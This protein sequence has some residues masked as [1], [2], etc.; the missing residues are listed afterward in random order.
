ME[1]KPGVKLGR[2]EILSRIG[3]GGMGQVW[4]AR[5]TRLGR[6]VAVK[7]SN[8]VFSGRFEREAQAIS[9]LNHPNICTLYDVGPDY[10]VMELVEGETLSARLAR[11]PL[12]V[13]L[14][15]QY[16]AQIAAALTEA[17]S[18]RI[19]HR[20]LKPANIML[21]RTGVKILDFGVAKM[22]TAEATNTISGA[23]L[24]TP[25][26]MA[27]EQIEGKPSDSRTDI[28]ALG[29]VLYEM[30]TGRRLSYRQPP[31]AEDLPAALAPIILRC[32]ETDPAQ[33][34]DS[35]RDVLEQLKLSNP[36]VPALA[37]HPVPR[38]TIVWLAGA[39]TLGAGA[40]WLTKSIRNGSTPPAVSVVIPIPVGAATADPGRLL[41]PPV[42][43]P[44]GNAVVVS[45]KTTQGDALFIR[46]LDSD[47]LVRLD[48][49]EGASYPF[50]SPDSKHMGFF[51]GS[52]MKRLPA[53]G[54]APATICDAPAARGGAWGSRGTIIFGNGLGA[55]FN[56]SES[57]GK[58]A[59]ATQL[60]KATGENSHRYPVFLPDGNR[61]LY[62]A[63]TDN[64]EKRGIYMEALNRQ[65]SR[66]RIIQADGQFALGRDPRSGRYSILTQQA[67]KIVAQ[68]FDTGRGDL[69]GEPY[70]LLNRAGQVSVSDS[71]VLL[72]RPEK[73]D[74]SRLVWRDRAGREIG[75]LGS[76]NDYWGVALSPD[77][78]FAAAVK[79]DYLS[80]QFT[81]WMAQLPQGL[82]EPFSS[83]THAYA[84]AWSHDSMA[85][86]YCDFRQGKLFRRT[87]T[88]AG[89]E[90]SVR[91]IRDVGNGSVLVRDISPDGR[92]GV[93]EISSVADRSEVAWIAMNSEQL[94]PTGA[95][96][97]PGLLPRLSPDGTWLAQASSQ[98]GN[99]EV[100]VCNFPDSTRRFRVS[101]N[102]GSAPEW[103]RDGKELFYVAAD[104]TMMAVDISTGGDLR[105]S[106]PKPLFRTALRRGSD[107]PLYSVSG[108]GQRFLM[109]EGL[110]EPGTSN[111]EMV[112]NWTS[113]PV[114]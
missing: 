114:R 58:P 83:L 43:A 93:F 29:L 97:R 14:T 85:L 60:D 71:G 16:G 31:R 35:A 59:A 64:I 12:P 79:H 32:L 6:S 63:R 98:T 65:H 1:L 67:G 42:V 99:L 26:Y 72:V 86:Y 87:V 76:P 50:W 75:T 41:G 62:F 84:M 33:R 23:V 45:L 54:G 82:L 113:L 70:T 95:T 106:T 47:Q 69:A 25:A 5:D 112:L 73:F 81:I 92:M 53:S 7:I 38:R 10:L 91:Q 36:Q 28:F 78:R 46:H 68:P 103:R 15:M 24:G 52:Q 9:S 22:E 77:D 11:G 104:G 108:D 3:S 39:A 105:S 109:I 102:G 20:D 101:V 21:T 61:F 107:A 57:G 66:R 74:V 88:V 49:T 8:S 18:Q 40:W 100:Y 94:H 19:V 30:A 80:G 89:L 44:D 13:D 111:I 56:V 55:I 90:E 4:K 27:P 110:D 37:A 17:H 2:Y 96:G 34:W 51:A 48:G